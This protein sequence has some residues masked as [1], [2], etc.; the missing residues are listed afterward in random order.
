MEFI[1]NKLRRYTTFSKRKTG[2]MKKAYELST[3]TGTQV[4][5]LVASETGHVYTFA[6]RKLQ[7]MITSETGKALIQTCLNS[8]DSPPRSDP[9]TD[10]RMSA[11]GFEE[12]DLTYQVSETDSS[13]ENKDGLKPTTFTVANV[14]GSTGTHQ[15]ASNTSTNLQ[16]SA[17]HNFPI[18]NYLAPVTAIAN[19]NGTT[20][21]PSASGTGSGSMLQFPSGFTL[22][23]GTP[24]PGTPTIPLSQLQPHSLTV[25]GQQGQ[26]LSSQSQSGQ[27]TVFRFPATSGG[28]IVSIAGESLSNSGATRVVGVLGDSASSSS[29]DTAPPGLRAGQRASSHATDG[30]H[31]RQQLRNLS[32][33][34]QRDNDI[35]G[36]HRDVLGAH[37]SGEPRDVP[38]PPRDGHVHH[39]QPGAGRRGPDRPER[40][41]VGLLRNA[42]LSRADAGAGRSVTSCPHGPLGHS[43]NPPPATPG[44]ARREPF[45]TLLM[46]HRTDGSDRSAD[47]VRG[48]DRAAGG[49]SGDYAQVPAQ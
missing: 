48:T 16:V 17:G 9:T 20:F 5:L 41:L 13:G 22:M 28:Q 24:L 23:S 40:F 29:G 34:D 49:Q 15:S 4:L 25:Q 6:T 18:T 38:Q 10:Q 7:P 11:T 44:M 26:M 47:C 19:S 31:Q 35:A 3:L 36:D 1:D 21:K 39:V 8:P 37:H 14:P 42:G 46:L 12:T 33:I 27:Q 45:R 32:G 2:I 30:H 43:T